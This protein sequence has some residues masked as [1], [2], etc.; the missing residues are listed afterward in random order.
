VVTV[1]LDHLLKVPYLPGYILSE[2][3]HHP[4]RAPN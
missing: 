2:L 3:A 1:E 4:E